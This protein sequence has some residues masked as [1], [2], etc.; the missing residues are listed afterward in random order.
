MATQTIA[1]SRKYKV[2]STGA[3]MRKSY[4]SN[5]KIV[6]PVK[7][8]ARVVATLIRGSWYRCEYQGYVGWIHRNYLV[9]SSS[10]DKGGNNASVTTVSKTETASS[11]KKPSSSNSNDTLT[12]EEQATREELMEEYE[13]YFNSY[14]TATSSGALASNMNGIFGM[15]YQFMSTV[16]PKVPGTEFGYTYMDKIVTKMPLLLMSPGKVEFMPGSTKTEKAGVVA[17]LASSKFGIKNNDLDTVLSNGGRYYGFQHSFDEYFLFVNQMCQSCAKFMGIDDVVV[18]IGGYKSKL[19]SFAWNKVNTND[20]SNYFSASECVCFYID[21][22]NTVTD[23][24]SNTT[25]ESQI[26]SKINS[27]SDVG[28]EISFLLGTQTGT[29]FELLDS[30]EIENTLSSIESI[31]D[32]Y[33]NG[34][35]L[36]KDLGSEFATVAAGGKLIFPEIWDD[37]T[38]TRSFDINIKLRT[39]DCDP[40]SWYLNICVP[41][42]FLIGL[43]APQQK[44]SNGYFSPF[45]VRAFYKG[46]FN[47]DMGIITDLS[48][49]KGKEGAWSINGLPT[50]VDVSMTIKDLYQAVLSITSEKHDKW[51]L[52]NTTL[53]DYMANLCGIN[54]NKPDI[55]RT[56]EIW[57]ML[58]TNRIKNLPN[59]LS[60]KFQNS[61][62]NLMMRA[63]NSLTGFLS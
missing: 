32:K 18:T 15:P 8:N 31:A 41:M 44:S 23:T 27:F 51:F 29:S 14:N 55:M 20:F 4:T 39:P 40:I 53:M 22:V 30:D 24:F 3:I 6:T 10:S 37:S 33:L 49:T 63:Y 17:E 45:L 56:F 48:F 11:K 13:N 52:N 58:K 16:D 2:I 7:G 42:C 26:A 50:E 43:V 19:S 28:K 61:A 34:N 21:S 60:L 59:N 9:F 54:I 35:Q 25:T 1:I 36:F 5:S 62:T 46:L 47:V 57:A 38:F 12:V